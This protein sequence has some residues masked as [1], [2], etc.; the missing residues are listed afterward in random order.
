MEMLLD[1]EE[2]EIP[3]EESDS[4]YCIL[5]NSESRAL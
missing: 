1:N 4:I 5:E 2:K 3:T